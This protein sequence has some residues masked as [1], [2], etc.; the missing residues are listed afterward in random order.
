MLDAIFSAKSNGS[1]KATARVKNFLLDD[2]RAS[3][4]SDSVTRMMDRHFTV[5]PNVQ[6]LVASFV[7]EPK[8]DSNAATRD[9]MCTEKNSDSIDCRVFLLV[10]A[11][12]E[13]LYICISL[14]YLMTLQD[15]FVSGL[16]SGNTEDKPKLEQST[17][18]SLSP[19]PSRVERQSS[20]STT[21]TITPPTKRIRFV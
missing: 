2:L 8:T 12:L 21:K 18:N 6:M 10:T 9:R 20:T 13:S 17:S 11:Q 5:D 7:F 3:N 16:P 1:Y 14:D 15:F 4:Q 19:P